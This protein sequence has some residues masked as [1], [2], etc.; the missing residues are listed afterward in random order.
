MSAVLIQAD[1]ALQRQFAVNHAHVVEGEAIV[2]RDYYQWEPVFMVGIVD[3]GIASVGGAL[4]P[5][6]AGAGDQ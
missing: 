1:V 2:A 4:S 6:L 3:Q 5:D